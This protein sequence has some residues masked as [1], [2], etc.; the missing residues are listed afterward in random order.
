MRDEELETQLTGDR[1]KGA[2]KGS[3]FFLDVRSLKGLDVF[4]G[5]SKAWRDWA[6]LARSYAET[7]NSTLG[8]LMEAAET[9]TDDVR[10]SNLGHEAR[11]AS[12]QL[13]TL[14]LHA[15][16]GAAMGRV[17]NADRSEG[18]LAWRNLV[19]RYEPAGLRYK[20]CY[21]GHLLET[22]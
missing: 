10:N 19:S 9:G 20:I 21:S 16:K 2:G 15:A 12:V 5:S 6:I 18:A 4:D 8:T 17:V 11:A 13:Y 22:C 3:E 7:M 1:G 14:L